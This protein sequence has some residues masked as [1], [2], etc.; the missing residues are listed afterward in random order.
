MG[1]SE[2]DFEEG[3][4]SRRKEGRGRI[5]GIVGKVTG[6]VADASTIDSL[7]KGVECLIIWEWQLLLP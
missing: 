5:R 3:E 1:C 4:N 6:M 2:S 7:G